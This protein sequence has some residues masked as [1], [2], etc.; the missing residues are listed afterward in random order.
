MIDKNL[1]REELMDLIKNPSHKGAISNSTFSHEGNNPMCGDEL[2][3]DVLI[4]DDEIQDIKYS[5]EACAICFASAEVLSD[6][7]IGKSLESITFQ[8]K[9]S[10]LDLLGITLTTSRV[11]CA[12]LPLETLKEGTE[13]W[14]NNKKK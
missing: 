13:I 14:K 10:L 2:T 7:L 11:K 3:M 9:E 8:T 5:G 6:E 4:K 12:M 1:Y